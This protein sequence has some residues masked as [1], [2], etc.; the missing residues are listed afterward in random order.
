M[1]AL[2]KACLPTTASSG[3]PLARAVR[4]KSLDSTSCIAPRVM[5][6][7]TAT[8]RMP[9][10]AAG[11]TRNAG[12]PEPDGGS[13]RSV[14]AKRRIS[15]SPTQYTGNETPRY[16]SSIAI[17]SKATPGRPAPRSAAGRPPPAPRIAWAPSRGRG[18]RASGS[19]EAS[20]PRPALA[21]GDHREFPPLHLRVLGPQIDGEP[22]VQP[23]RGAVHAFVDLTVQ[24]GARGIVGGA[25]GAEDERVRDRI[26]VKGIVAARP[27]VAAVEQREQEVVSVGVIGP[28]VEQRHVGLAG[29]GRLPLAGGVPLH[30]L[31]PGADLLDVGRHRLRRAAD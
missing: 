31:D 18:A 29:A 11:S 23:G 24:R 8:E 30:Q 27:E 9:S 17:R 19:R 25:P 13:Q 12:P 20:H 2:R 5:R 22:Q 6:A 7:R 15:S 3:S 16:E 28:P 4:M 10:V 1:Q 21:V 14:T 26:P